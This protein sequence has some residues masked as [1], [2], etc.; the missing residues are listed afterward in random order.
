MKSLLKKVL[1]LVIALSCAIG[2]F[3]GC[4]ED[5]DEIEIEEEIDT[6]RTQVYVSLINDGL[7]VE[8]M[9]NEIKA[10]FEKKFPQYQ[11]MVDKNYSE[12]DIENTASSNID[13]FLNGRNN[14]RFYAQGGHLAE[15][16]DWAI[17]KVYDDDYNYVGQGG[18]K[19]V[20]DRLNGDYKKV[21]DLDPSETGYEIYAVPHYEGTWGIWYDYD[22]LGPD[23]EGLLPSSEYGNGPDGL[24]GT[25]DDGLPRTWKEFTKLI[26]TIKESGLTPF[27]FSQI[28]YVRAAMFDAFIAGYEGKNDFDINFS[29]NGT[30]DAPVKDDL[31]N[32][33][34]EIN[35]QPGDNK[36]NFIL[37][38]K[39]YGRL[40][41]LTMVETFI[42]I[43]NCSQA[44]YSGQQHKD[45]Q[46]DFLMSAILPT[47]R[48]AMFME[49]AYWHNEARPVFNS[50]AK[51]NP[52]YAY[53]EREFR[54]LALPKFDGTDGTGVPATTNTGK[55][56]L[57]NTGSDAFLFVNKKSVNK[58]AVKDFFQWFN[59]NE[60]CFYFTKGSNCFRN[61][62][63]KFTP[64]QVAE[65]SPLSQDLYRYRIAENT[66]VCYE[67]GTSKTRYDQYNTFFNFNRTSKVKNGVKVDPWAYLQFNR[68]KENIMSYFNGMYSH[69]NSD[70]VSY[71]AMGV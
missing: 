27:G 17:E 19:S 25:P 22:L 31:G 70:A 16:T 5:L 50:M 32:D 11:L 1:V 39:Q 9:E 15:V 26:S 53:G 12:N 24:P 18:T 3:A 55:T 30:L 45:A 43:D 36:A 41:A 65:L 56:T 42:D 6:T 61:I 28:H 48:I 59:G 7:G 69:W 51:N 34:Y 13:L 71:T 44:S 33:V 23:G 52:K 38:Q 68:G 57:Y 10:G 64:E 54:Y 46:Q 60:A 20:Y 66:E 4:G 29:F 58:Q 40:A 47:G 14:Y 21:Y 35:C 37:L 8:W 2:S 62:E 49:G 67:L 63:F